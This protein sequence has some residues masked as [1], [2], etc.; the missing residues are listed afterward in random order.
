MERD[1]LKGKGFRPQKIE[2]KLKKAGLG[3]SYASYRLLC[4][5]AHNDLTT[6]N[7]RHSEQHLRYHHEAPP[8]V[9]SGMLQIAF[10]LL[11]EAV[12][13]LPKFS[14]TNR[15]RRNV[16]RRDHSGQLGPGKNW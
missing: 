12:A 3:E 8:S 4:G 1:Y 5:Y 14:N 7:V 6:L 16:G 2:D 11:T 13:L 9:T 10:R 15:L